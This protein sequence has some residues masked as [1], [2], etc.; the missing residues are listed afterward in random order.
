MALAVP[1][2]HFSS[3]FRPVD[4]TCTGFIGFR[5]RH[6]MHVGF[7]EVLAHSKENRAPPMRCQQYTSQ[8]S[9]VVA[10]NPKP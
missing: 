10:L 1:Q 5:V 3:K 2:L 4:A 9:R 8:T 7:P 6:G